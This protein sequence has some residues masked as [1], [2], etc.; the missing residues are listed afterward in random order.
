MP[1]Q[2]ISLK[3]CFRKGRLLVQLD[4]SQVFPDDPGQGTPAIVRCFQYHAPYWC[5]IDNGLVDR[6]GSYLLLTAAEVDWLMSLDGEI[7]KFL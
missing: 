4:K 7:T 2:A 3:W 5:A 1:G 6:D